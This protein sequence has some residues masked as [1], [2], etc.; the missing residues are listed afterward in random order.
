MKMNWQPKQEG[1]DKI[2]QLLRESQ[3]TDVQ[4]QSQVQQKLEQ[5]NTFSDFNNYLVFVLA[6]IQNE[7]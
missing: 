1:L 6:R 5:Y 7:G 3:S 4:T 2:L